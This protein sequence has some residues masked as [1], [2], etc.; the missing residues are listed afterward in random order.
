M[1]VMIVLVIVIHTHGFIYTSNH[2]VPI[3]KLM[4]REV[5]S[6]DLR[7]GSL[8]GESGNGSLD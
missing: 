3:L 6:R 7:Q 1:M 4:F 8:A 2:H 5:N